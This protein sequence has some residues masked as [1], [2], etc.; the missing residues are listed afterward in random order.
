MRGRHSGALLFLPHHFERFAFPRR[1]GRVI[2]RS[3]T[4]TEE[5]RALA[6]EGATG[7]HLGRRAAPAL[8]SA[9]RG[10][11]RNFW[12]AAPAVPAPGC[13]FSRRVHRLGSG[14]ARLRAR[15]PIA[16]E[17]RVI[18]RTRG[19][20]PARSAQ[21]GHSTHCTGQTR[22]PRPGPCP[23]ESQWAGCL[24]ARGP[25]G[26]LGKRDTPAQRRHRACRKAWARRAS[27]DLQ[28]LWRP[29]CHPA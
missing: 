1:V 6:R 4:G 20:E 24:S 12:A 3:A 17:Q 7:R 10:R 11:R 16:S 13:A 21:S 28:G 27:S 19:P 23:R 15:R 29:C 22:S 25:A 14:R 26:E 8:N 2:V 18:V 5:R 9:P